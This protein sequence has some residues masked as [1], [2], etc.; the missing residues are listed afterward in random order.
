MTQNSEVL[1]KPTTTD[2]VKVNPS[3]VHKVLNRHMLADGFEL[4]VDLQRSRG[5]YFL[6][7]MRSV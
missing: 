6:A 5:A 1:K 2:P 3:E 4:I 7:P